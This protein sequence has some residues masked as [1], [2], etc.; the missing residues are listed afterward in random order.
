M[1]SER[2]PGDPGPFSAQNR[3]ELR[4]TPAPPRAAPVGGQS[5]SLSWDGT[6]G[7]SFDVQL[8]RDAAFA[9]LVLE[10]RVDAPA[11]ELPLPGSGRFF[12]RLRARDPDGFVGPYTT[13]QHFDM[14]NCLRSSDG[15]CVEAGGQ[16]VLV[17]P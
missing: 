4:P 13:P 5:I 15:A 1:A 7:Q 16:P 2:D 11:V 8:A 10:R 6:P 9:T 12:V 3:F 17:G 14:P